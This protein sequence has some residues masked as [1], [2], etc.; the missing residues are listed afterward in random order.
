MRG[1]WRRFGLY[2]T[3]VAVL[4]AIVLIATR[5]SGGGFGLAAAQV[6]FVGVLAYLLT[7]FIWPRRTKLS[8]QHRIIAESVDLVVDDPTTEPKMARREPAAPERPVR[9]VGPVPPVKNPRPAADSHARET[10]VQRS[11]RGRRPSERQATGEM[12]WPAR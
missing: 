1:G 11:A 3:V 6:F 4:V 9:K 12:R 2:I 10:P 7:F 8:S 5:G